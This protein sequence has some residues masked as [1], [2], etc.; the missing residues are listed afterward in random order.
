MFLFFY[1]LLYGS[2]SRFRNIRF[3][4]CHIVLTLS[5]SFWDSLAI[6]R[7]YVSQVLLVFQVLLVLV[8]SLIINGI[9]PFVTSNKN[10]SDN[11]EMGGTV[12]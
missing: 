3:F 8:V 4:V 2:V 5:S 6:L 7:V 1:Y 9:S 12:I 10:F 11:Q